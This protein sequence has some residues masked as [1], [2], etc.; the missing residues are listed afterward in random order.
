MFKVA[1]LIHGKLLFKPDDER[2]WMELEQIRTHTMPSLTQKTG[3]MVQFWKHL[4]GKERPIR[5][6]YKS[7][8]EGGLATILTVL[9]SLEERMAGAETA[10][11]LV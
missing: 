5:L 11:V 3:Y 9:E 8:K 6:L 7:W 1:H 2:T 10:V 4:C